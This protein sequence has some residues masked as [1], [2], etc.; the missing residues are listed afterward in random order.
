MTI[1]PRLLSLFGLMVVAGQVAAVTGSRFVHRPF[2]D[3]ST[4]SQSLKQA[5]PG[6][7]SS[8]SSGPLAPSSA[9]WSSRAYRPR[10][11]PLDTSGFGAL[12]YVMRSWSPTASLEEISQTWQRAG[13]KGVAVVDQRLSGADR[14]MGA[15]V[16]D[17]FL[18]AALLNY[19]GE[20]E[21]SYKLLRDLRSIVEGDD[22][23][24]QD[25]LG[26]VIY[27]Q[28]RGRLCALAKTT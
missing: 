2:A 28:G 5:R 24:A 21:Q 23:L 6:G 17:T 18:K 22:Q 8:I 7:P 3:S 15:Q 10:H 12:P 11:S 1:R 25:S 26:T 16:A 13:F 20:V 27:F 9:R 14:A 4:E 19:E